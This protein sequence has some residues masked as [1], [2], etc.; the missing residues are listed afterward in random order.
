MRE[1]NVKCR[2][3]KNSK[4]I[5]ENSIDSRRRKKVRNVG[6][7]YL[8]HEVPNFLGYEQILYF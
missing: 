4:E 1:K 5:E 8:E 3:R 6:N 2:H 7:F